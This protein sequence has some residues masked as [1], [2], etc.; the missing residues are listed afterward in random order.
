MDFSSLRNSCFDHS[1]WDRLL[2]TYVEQGADGLNRV[3]YSG[4]TITY[5]TLGVLLARVQERRGIKLYLLAVA[6][7]LA[8]P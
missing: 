2:K 6:T 5:L 7:F 3:N 4:A 8:L 1:A